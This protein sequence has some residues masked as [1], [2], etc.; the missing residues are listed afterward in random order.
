[1]G[2]Y[3]FNVWSVY[4][5]FALFVG[6]NLVV[7]VRRHRQ[8]LRELKRRYNRQQQQSGSGLK[9]G[10]CP[11]QQSADLPGSYGLPDEN[12]DQTNGLTGERQ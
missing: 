1:M 6:V 5:I 12:R 8:I 3:G 7:P 11:D 4:V 2:G 9:P 10:Q